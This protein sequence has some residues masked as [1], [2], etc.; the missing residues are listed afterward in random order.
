MDRS[1]FDRALATVDAAL[2][3]FFPEDFDARC[4]YAAFGVRDLLRAAGQPAEIVYGD[5]L[6]FMTSQDGRDALF[7][8]FGTA[9]GDRP[10]HFWVEAAG[11][12]LDL[13][14]YYLVRQARFRAAPIPPLCWKLA[15][16]LPIY[17]RYRVL[18]RCDPD[19]EL[20]PGD[21]LVERVAGFRAKCLEVSADAPA[22]PWPWALTNP[23]AVTQAARAGDVWASGALHVLK[24]AHL[25]RLPF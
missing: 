12:R 4:M 3:Q 16:P 9:D 19:V 5:F 2:R 18:Q 7:T 23:G 17:L 14:P 11:Y 13:G 21:P 6:C 10:S 1:G 8:G 22:A 20:P 15:A 25:Q 24:Q